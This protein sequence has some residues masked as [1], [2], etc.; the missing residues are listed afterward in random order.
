MKR[1][2]GVPAALNRGFVQLRPFWSTELSDWKIWLTTELAVTELAEVTNWP[3]LW[4][5][6]LTNR[7][8][9]AIIRSYWSLNLSKF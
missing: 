4:F 3:F 2:F 1:H 5:D 7:T 9:S 6:R 8:A